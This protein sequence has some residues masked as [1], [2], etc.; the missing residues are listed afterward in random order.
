[1]GLYG[2]MRTGASGMSAQSNR[3][4]TVA[5]NIA[6]VGTTG[7]KRA[8]SEFSSLVLKSG[9]SDY[10]SGS[11]DSRVRYAVSEQGS[12]KFTTSATD[13]AV[14][15]NGFFIVSNEAGQTFL[16]RAGVIRAGRQ[17]QPRQ[18]RG[19]QAHGL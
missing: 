14:K 4:G 3:L 11:V 6:N 2:M 5:D 16:T 18:F 15:G 13:L 7:Y 1:M 12:F 19:L 17:R 9:Q 8:S 10:L